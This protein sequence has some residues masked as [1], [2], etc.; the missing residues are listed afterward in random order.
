MKTR[1]QVSAFVALIFVAMSSMTASAAIIFWGSRNPD[2]FYD[3]TGTQLDSAFVFEVGTFDTTGGWTPTS[4]NMSEWAGRW[5]LFDRATVGAGWNANDQA[6][7]NTVEHTITGGSNSPEAN[8]AHS[9]SQGSQAYLWVYNTQSIVTGAEWAL[10]CDSDVLSNVFPGAWVFPDPA[11][12]GGESYDWQTRDLDTAI[13]GGVNGVQGD[14]SYS[15]NP[16][17]F[18]I[19]THVVP[20][21]GSALML[22]TAGALLLLRR[23]HS[24]TL[25]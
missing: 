1:F 9:F 17:T 7:D 11:E 2:F 20:E 24:L 16:G 4:S 15:V 8:P 21:P 10:V 14:G 12:Q 3:S 22:F 13:F 5:M 18:T 25:I 19:Q 23:R 6:L